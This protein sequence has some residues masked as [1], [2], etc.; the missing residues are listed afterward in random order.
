MMAG[1]TVGTKFLTIPFWYAL[2]TCQTCLILLSWSFWL[3]QNIPKDKTMSS[4]TPL[5]CH[6][7]IPER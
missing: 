5:K 6:Q 4:Q 7:S 3:N 2:V 1:F